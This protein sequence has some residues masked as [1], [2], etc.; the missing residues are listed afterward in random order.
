MIKIALL[1]TDS[2]EHFKD[3]ANPNPYFG[4]APEAL[5]EGFKLMPDDI[6]V[7]V[8][9]CLQKEPVSSPAT[10]ADNI[11]YHALH[12]PNIG[13]LKTG[14]GGCIVATRRK[15][16]E[17]RPDIVH[18][19]G[20]ERD[21]GICSV[22]SGYKSI[23]TLHG[24]MASLYP[25]LRKNAWAYYTLARAFERFC[26]KHANGVVCISDSV[27]SSIQHTA[28]QVWRIPNAI[29]SEFLA[30]KEFDTN[31]L[32][33]IPHFI[34]VGIISPLKR[35]N[36][37]LEQ[38]LSMRLRYNFRVTFVGTQT[39]HSS[40][41][42]KFSLLLQKAQSQHSGFTH[43]PYL[44]SS[45]LREVFDS[46]DALIHWS[47]E[48][49]FGLVL[50]EARARQMFVFT[51]K[52]GAAQEICQA[53]PTSCFVYPEGQLL[54]LQKDLAEWLERRMFA[55]RRPNAP[56]QHIGAKMSPLAVAQRH[57]R[58]YRGILSDPTSR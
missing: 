15:L 31:S 9:S 8:V 1:T 4:T 44:A 23:L 6:E 20:T 11:Y 40:Y 38:L 36:E 27:E 25:K 51:S 10:L 53:S 41:G 39:H 45:A 12:V 35:Q 43:I 28:R 34:N 30:P 18:G 3:Y 50:A 24:V 42:R 33:Y 26:V 29:R 57:L 14:Y 46:S 17:I 52:V 56:N 2:R 22:L 7:H 5:L 48:E 21:C 16:Q 49:S 32:D 37:L 13:W 54:D 47:Q 58:V 19:Q 55:R